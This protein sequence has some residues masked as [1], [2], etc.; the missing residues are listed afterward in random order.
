LSRRLAVVVGDVINDVVV[1][2]LGPMAVG[3]DTPSHVVAV[4][5]GSGANQAAWLGSF[6]AS[7]RFVGRAGREDAAIHRAALERHGVEALITVDEAALTGTIVVLVGPAGERSMFTD[8]GAS[9]ALCEEDLPAGLLE[10]ASL[11]HVSGYSLFAEGPRAAVRRLWAA[12]LG[13]G[14]TATV[15]P[16]SLAGLQAVGASSF[17]EW[18]AGAAIVFPNL[19]EGRLLTGCDE[20]EEIVATLLEHYPAVALKIG[21]A[22]AIVGSR[23]GRR[24]RSPAP[25]ATVVDTTGAGDAFSAG[26]LAT[27]LDGGDLSTCAA[28]AVAAAARAVAVVGARP[29]PL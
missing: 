11:L 24:F 27:W 3:T 26:F 4:P 9:L 2:P 5:G 12:A 8:R 1:R 10:G 25:F 7:V 19:D 6:E 14:V 18:T 21:G 29:P 15:D 20:P 23:D 28:S 13:A 16:S 22:G 17:L